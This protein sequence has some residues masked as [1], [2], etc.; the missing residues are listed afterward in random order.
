[1]APAAIYT[2]EATLKG[3]MMTG[4][5]PLS[6]ESEEVIFSLLGYNCVN[7]AKGKK[8]KKVIVKKRSQKNFSHLNF[9]HQ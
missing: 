6:G 3:A 4:L 1:M 9:L 8:K 2:H 5:K 7:W